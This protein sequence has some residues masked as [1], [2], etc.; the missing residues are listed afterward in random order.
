MKLPVRLFLVVQLLLAGS[1]AGIAQETVL[2]G[3]TPIR[4]DQGKM[5]AQLH[6]RVYRW[7][8]SMLPSEVSSRSQVAGSIKLLW[9]EN[10]RETPLIP[11][12]ITVTESSAAR[13]IVEAT[14]TP[15]PGIKIQSK[16]VLDYDG[17]ATI[18]LD[19]T[20]SK[21]TAVHGLI[22]ETQVPKRSSSEVLAFRAETIRLRHTGRKDIIGNDDVLDVPYA[23]DFLNVFDF[24]DGDRSFWWF[25]DN[26]AGW[27]WGGNNAT[28]VSARGNTYVLRQTFLGNGVLL[29]T[30]KHI[31]FGI[32]ATPVRP[33]A[34]NWRMQRLTSWLPTA[35]DK[36][37]NAKIFFY[38]EKGLAYDG[39]PY[40]HY[41]ARVHST[42]PASDRAMYPGAEANKKF[43]RQYRNRYG[44]E[45]LPYYPLHLLS[46][47]DPIVAENRSKWEFDPPEVWKDIV[48][49]YPFRREKIQV[50]LRAPGVVDHIITGLSSAIDELDVNGF[51]FDHAPVKDSK[52]PAHGGWIDCKG[53][54]RGSLDIWATRE[55]FR[56]LR[57][58][59]E[60][61]GKPGIVIVHDSNRGIIP[62]YTFV[63]GVLDGEQFR[64]HLRKADYLKLT[65]I[66]QFR[67]RFSPNQYGIPTY[68]LAGEWYHH[69]SDK[70]WPRS[71]D[72]RIA[73]RRMMALAL[74]HDVLD[75]PHEAHP[76][77]REWLLKKLDAFDIAASEFHGYWTGSSA[78]VSA[79]ADV[80]I[81]KYLHSDK[82][83][84]LYVVVNTGDTTKNV[85]LIQRQDIGSVTV[86]QTRGVKRTV[87]RGE[88]IR[89]TI[90]SRDFVLITA[91][92]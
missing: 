40:A 28:E 87:K 55:L 30:A 22:L 76:L 60:R 19:I 57:A 80:L 14:S 52:K 33:M 84:S 26:A 12:Q 10:G 32:L 74:L 73:Y 58:E 46:E 16:T 88:P 23:G 85:D 79:D 67:A 51:Y 29:S 54:L 81:S 25:A 70:S 71:E 53:R 27:D 64:T 5:E 56:R 48:G 45:L 8:N 41:P 83:S 72:S 47:I 11:S 82:L 37:L 59:F 78:L 62:A 24:S 6:E 68:W 63:F 17:V 31:Q 91:R 35:K 36:E 3:F 38:W 7:S 1:Q 15:A 89:V 61:R 65:S 66:S 21:P 92:D 77:E 39:L 42:L 9:R 44:A 13:V 90:P 20:A 75:W 49:L 18:S 34:D 50:S 2:S 4:F 86:E 69:E 43:L